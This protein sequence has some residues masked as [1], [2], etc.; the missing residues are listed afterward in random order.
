MGW[1]RFKRDNRIDP[2]D[3]ARLSRG[4]MSFDGSRQSGLRHFFAL[5]RP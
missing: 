4:G 3:S 5:D 2:I 1:F